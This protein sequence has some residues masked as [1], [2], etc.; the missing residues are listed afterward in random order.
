MKLST[1]LLLILS[2][3]HLLTMVNFL[4]L[5]SALNDLVFWFNSTFFMAAFALYFW[6][7]NKDTEKND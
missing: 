1:L 7:F 3:M 6:K 4:L 2:V 5:D